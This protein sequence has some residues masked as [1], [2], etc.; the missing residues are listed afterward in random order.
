MLG[1]AAPA[2]VLVTAPFEV[3]CSCCEESAC[4][5]VRPDLWVVLGPAFDEAV[6]SSGACTQVTRDAVKF[7]GNRVW[8]GTMTASDRPCIVTVTLNGSQTQQTVQ[9]PEL[10]GGPGRAT[11]CFGAPEEC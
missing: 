8:R 11:A 7:G 9:S 2:L 5:D 6:V 3:A 1:L 10:C 4:D